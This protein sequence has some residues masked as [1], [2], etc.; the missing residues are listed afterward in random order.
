MALVLDI[1]IRSR[2]CSSAE[3]F[4]NHRLNRRLVSPLHRFNRCLTPLWQ[5]FC[6]VSRTNTSVYTDARRCIRW[7]K[8]EP[9]P[10][11]GSSGAYAK[12]LW[13][14]QRLWT[15]LRSMHRRPADGSSGAPRLTP[16]QTH[17]SRS[18]LL[19]WMHRRSFICSI[20]SSGAS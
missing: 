18:N 12:H 13:L 4:L 6:I 3:N 1:W 17:R 16:V 7:L 2:V 11:C 10:F 15:I 5:V 20:G 9:M 19:R 8:E 14:L